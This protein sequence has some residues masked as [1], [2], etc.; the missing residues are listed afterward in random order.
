MPAYSFKLKLQTC[1]FSS[2]TCSS[3]SNNNNGNIDETERGSIH[4]I[5]INIK[6]D[7]VDVNTDCKNACW[8]SLKTRVTWI[9]PSIIRDTHGNPQ[10]LLYV[11]LL[12]NCKSKHVYPSNEFCFTE[13]IS[14]R[15]DFCI[16]SVTTTM[17]PDNKIIGTDCS[18]N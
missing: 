7:N 12:C 16:P 4:K 3:S 5:Q 15:C 2:N 9:I 13:T 14:N 10:I 6:D 1:I 11:Y 17:V 8:F 18:W